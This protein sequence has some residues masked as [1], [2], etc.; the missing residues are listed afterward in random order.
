MWLKL[1]SAPADVDAALQKARLH[2][3]DVS[4]TSQVSGHFA[5]ILV[6]YQVLSN[7]RQRELYD[8]S[9]SSSSSGV[10]SAAREGSRSA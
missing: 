1:A 2:H 10:H 9:L 5:K 3:P 4:Q 7:D 6:A 8:L